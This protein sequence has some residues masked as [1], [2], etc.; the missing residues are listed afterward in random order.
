MRKFFRMV[1]FFLGRF[2][3]KVR[4]FLVIDNGGE[5]FGLSSLL[6]LGACFLFIGR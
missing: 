2:S 1:L 5:R 6:V 4:V 3:S